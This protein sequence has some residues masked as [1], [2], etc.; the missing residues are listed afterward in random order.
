MAEISKNR[1]MSNLPNE[2]VSISAFSSRA[3]AL[4]VA[5]LKSPSLMAGDLDI[6]LEVI[7]DSAPLNYAGTQAAVV[8]QQKDVGALSANGFSPAV[9]FQSKSSGDGAVTAGSEL[10]ESIW[11]GVF[12]SGSKTGDGSMHS[13]TA[14]GE[15]GAYGAGA[16]SEYGL[17]QGEATN[18][19]SALGTISG[20]EVLLKDSPDGG[21]S[22]YS[23]K[24]QA[25]VGRIA[26]YNP[27]TRKSYNFYGSSEGTLN[28]NAVLGINPSGLATWQRGIDFEG[29][30]FSSG[31]AILLPNNTSIASLNTSAASKAILL[32]SSSNS[33]VLAM[34]S[35]TSKITLTN[36][37]FVTKF[38]V[39]DASDGVLVYVG[40]ALKRVGQGSADSAGAGFRNLIVAN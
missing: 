17:F 22:N 33:T 26:K 1:Q 37:S 38:E 7:K 3:E 15:L 25:V 4:T 21:T 14:T 20:V 29:A 5:T 27:T 39:D 36:A 16:Y 23:T 10:S 13:F 28:P 11:Q 34:E 24:M 6:A 9:V 31:E 19:G 12:S 35:N 40:G 30:T 32:L 18:I 2:I 8:V